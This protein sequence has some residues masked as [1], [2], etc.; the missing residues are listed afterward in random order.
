MAG[1]SK[2]IFELHSF[3]PC[4]P[5]LNVDPWNAWRRFE[6]RRWGQMTQ[7]PFRTFRTSRSP[8]PE[9]NILGR[10]GNK[11]VNLSLFLIKQHAMK[12]YV[13]GEV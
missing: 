8:V 7:S 4:E 9:S 10:Y 13:L 12:M 11:Y 6:T 2:E 3:L 1:I 5:F